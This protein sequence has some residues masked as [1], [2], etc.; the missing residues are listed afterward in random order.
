MKWEDLKVSASLQGIDLEEKAG[1]KAQ[2]SF[3][4]KTEQ[5]ASLFKDP[6]E[7]NKMSKEEAE[8]A[9]QKMMGQHRNWVGDMGEM[10]SRD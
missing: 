1:D 10:I 7:Y 5:V 6:E 8:E 3:S 4:N 2:H 9:T